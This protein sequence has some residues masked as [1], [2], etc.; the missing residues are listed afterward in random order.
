MPTS[1][2]VLLADGLRAD[3][4]RHAIDGGALPALARLRANGALSEVTSVFPSVTG[5]AYVPFLLGRFPASVGVPGLRWYD[6]SR[7]ATS[8]PDYSRSY[9][10]YQMNAVNRDLRADAPTI[11]ELA[12]GSAGALSMITRGLPRSGQ[13][14]VLNVRSAVRAIRT[15]FTGNL[16]EWLA[17]DRETSAKV[18]ARAR[19]GDTP[20][21]FAAFMGVDK[22]SHATGQQASAVIDALRVVDTTV[23]ALR[24]GTNARVWIASDH[25]HSPVQHHDDLHQL[26]TR[27]GVRV[28]AHPWVYTMQADVAV[29]VSG[30]AMAHVY[31]DLGHRTRPFW[32]A[33]ASRYEATLAT[34]LNRESVDIALVPL[35]ADRCEV[36][37]RA[38]GRAVV[39]LESNLLSYH[40]TNGDPLDI[41]T[42]VSNLDR[43][44]AWDVTSAT[45]YPDSLVQ[46]AALAR[47]ER[48][49]DVVLSAA[50]GW[51]FRERYEPIPHVSSHGAL[52]RDH[53]SVPL[54][55]DAPPA[56]QPRRTTDVFPSALA[57][58]GITAPA[59]LDGE[60]FLASDRLE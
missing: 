24:E 4:L 1:V 49:G 28:R 56:R 26:L 43:A 7:R 58:L 39:S 2:I 41:G 19:R 34:L 12:P 60:S 55:L 36:R 20:F 59:A 50:R 40:R 53:M 52:H 23:A 6:R 48:C 45:D 42:D 46:I 44:A 27:M 10:G 16:A 5:P 17:V 13:L 37:S 15:H 8:F 21:I 18:I 38:R 30:N 31:F 35:S 3:T 22:L 11:Y 54:L 25:G 29:M 32:G 51:D 57:A 33:L 9:V 14:A 47:A